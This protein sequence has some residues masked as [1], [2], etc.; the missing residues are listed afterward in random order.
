MPRSAKWAL[1]D[2]TYTSEPW[3]PLVAK[4]ALVSA[5]VDPPTLLRATN[6]RLHPALQEWLA[7]RLTRLWESMPTSGNMTFLTWLNETGRLLKHIP[8]DI[9]AHSIDSAAVAGGGFVPGAAAIL[10][11]AAPLHAERKR[12][13]ER[14]DTIVNGSR[15][16]AKRPW[17]ET[18]IQ[19]PP[20]GVCTPEQAAEI[21]RDYGI[22]RAEAKQR[23]ER[24]PLGMPTV[25]DYLN[26]APT[27]SHEDAEKAIAGFR[28]VPPQ[29]SDWQEAGS[30]DR[31][32]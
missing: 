4:Q 19:M 31:Q 9:L 11:I 13:R 14:L 22:A 12:Q 10:A 32:S 15:R 25:E 1:A 8:R 26:M 3:C 29:R 5:K 6:D 7:G 27:M 28:Q 18:L 23:R 20:E 17:E 21:M 30:G 24:G 16:P 2:P